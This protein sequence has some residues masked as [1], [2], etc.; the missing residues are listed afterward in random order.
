MGMLFSAFI[1]ENG[2]LFIMIRWTT[3]H[4][5]PCFVGQFLVY[6][7]RHYKCAHITLTAMYIFCVFFFVKIMFTM[8]VS[9]LAN[10]PYAIGL[11]ILLEYTISFHHKMNMK[12]CVFPWTNR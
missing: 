8:L 5:L 3:K 11:C 7:L 12:I 4:F 10:L 1:H 9:K 2:R 6:A